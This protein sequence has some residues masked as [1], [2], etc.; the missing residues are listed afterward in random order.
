MLWNNCKIYILHAIRKYSKEL[1]LG[2]F[3]AKIK[4]NVIAQ[5]FGFYE[6]IFFRSVNTGI[7]WKNCQAVP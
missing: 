3:C 4:I 7:Y 6:Y 5:M 1:K 2:A